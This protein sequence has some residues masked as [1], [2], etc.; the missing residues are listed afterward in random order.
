MGQNTNLK[1]CFPEHKGNN[2]TNLQKRISV[3]VTFVNQNFKKLIQLGRNDNCINN[4]KISCL[5]ESFE[6]S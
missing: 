5:S 4:L 6:L 2:F 1:F 3:I